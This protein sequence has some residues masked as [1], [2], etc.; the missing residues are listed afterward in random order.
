MNKLAQWFKKKTISPVIDLLKQGVSPQKIA[1]ALVLGLVLAYFPVYG[2][3]T[4]LCA[5]FIWL[6]KLNPVAVYTANYLGS[7]LFFGLYV[8]MIRGGEWLFQAP[9]VNLNPTILMEMIAESIPNTIVQ[10]WNSTLYAMV[11]WGITS[12]PIYLIFRKIFAILLEKQQKR[13]KKQPFE[14]N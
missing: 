13:L 6:L 8:P 9:R 11:F 5:L 10:L 7:P 4:L 2:S 14:T 3:H 12:I 1:E